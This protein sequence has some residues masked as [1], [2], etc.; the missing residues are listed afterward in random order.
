MSRVRARMLVGMH[1]ETDAPQVIPREPRRALLPR[2]SQLS[3]GRPKPRLQLRPSPTLGCER[4][5]KL[6]NTLN[7]RINRGR[8]GRGSRPTL[9]LGIADPTPDLPLTQGKEG[10]AAIAALDLDT[11]I[12]LGHR[13]P[14][15]QADP[16]EPC[17]V[18]T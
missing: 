6:T 2:R 16:A 1:K 12:N 3:L 5:L 11:V 9:E 8:S 17:P 15:R 14:P 10:S 13:E 7:G 18:R 4:R